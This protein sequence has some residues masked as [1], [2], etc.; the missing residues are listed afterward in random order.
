MKK[1]LTLATIALAGLS[2]AACG[3]NSKEAKDN[4]SLK[5]ENSS[6]KAKKKESENSS[7]KAENESLKQQKQGDSD[8]NTKESNTTKSAPTSVNNGDEAI[9]VAKAKYGDNNGDWKWECLTSNGSEQ[10]GEGYYFVKAISQSAID[11]GSMT[12][13]AMSMKVWPNGSISDANTG[14][15]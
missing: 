11:N 6:L 8:S 13:T 14:N 4:S 12:G 10:S 5:A 3:N 9:Q 7:L 15:Y 1:L 2:L